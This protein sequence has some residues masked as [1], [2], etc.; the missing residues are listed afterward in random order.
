[1]RAGTASDE[2][3][4]PRI[5]CRKTEL[6]MGSIVVIEYSVR[7]DIRT[8]IIIVIVII[9]LLLLLFVFVKTI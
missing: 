9:L 2:I 6:G 7:M 1:M 4:N 8:I 3:S 5:R